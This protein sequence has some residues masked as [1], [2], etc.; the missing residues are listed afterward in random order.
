MIMRTLIRALTWIC[1]AL[2]VAAQTPGYAD[3]HYGLTSPRVFYYRPGI[4]FSLNVN[5][6]FTYDT[7]EL[8]KHNESAYTWDYSSVFKQTIYCHE[9]NDG[10]YYAYQLPI[11]DLA[12]DLNYV[13][14]AYIDAGKSTSVQLT[15]SNMCCYCSFNL[16]IVSFRIEPPELDSCIGSSK[17]PVYSCLGGVTSLFPGGNF[18]Y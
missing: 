5:V 17:L 1:L 12:F 13:G 6:D 4:G 14:G 9:V 2:M 7:F 18:R 3:V 11:G 10:I 15:E 16:I 8:D